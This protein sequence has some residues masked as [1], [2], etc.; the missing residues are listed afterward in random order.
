M[1]VPLAKLLLSAAQ[2]LKLTIKGATKGVHQQRAEIVRRSFVGTRV[3]VE[4]GETEGSLRQPSGPEAACIQLRL[5][6][7]DIVFVPES[8]I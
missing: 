6:P 4:V 1:L 8:P 3:V 7:G 5:Q 2:G